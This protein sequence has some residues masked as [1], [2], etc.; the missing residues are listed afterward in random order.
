MDRIR[1]GN[2]SSIRTR[3][4]S[5]IQIEHQTKLSQDETDLAREGSFAKMRQEFNAAPHCS[6]EEHALECATQGR[7]FEDQKPLPKIASSDLYGLR[8]GRFAVF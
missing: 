2:D 4:T 8:P 6:A 1:R 3:R 5:E 7:A